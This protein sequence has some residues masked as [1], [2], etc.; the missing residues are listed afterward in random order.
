MRRLKI[1]ERK[2]KC[3]ICSE[4]DVKLKMIQE[5]NKKYY[6]ALNCHNIYL[7]DKEYKQKE[8]EAKLRLSKKIAEVY[9]LETYKL[10]PSSFYPYIEDLRNDSELFG[11]M[12]KNY[13][14]G[15]P[16]D[17]IAYAYEYCRTKILDSK[18][19]KQGSNDDFNNFLAELKY[20]LAIVKNNLADAKNEF[21]RKQQSKKVN[22]E[23]IKSIADISSSDY[24]YVSPKR[25]DELNISHLLQ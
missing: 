7:K 17:G 19:R 8:S 15:I 14:Q 5:T 24:H 9:E 4:S 25:K 22:Y 12:G 21:D 2:V 6:H 10:I 13:K 16:Y 1:A 23:N 18:A 11:R 20:G 3:Q